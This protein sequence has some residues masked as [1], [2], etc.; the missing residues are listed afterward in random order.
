M[1][2]KWIVALV[3]VGLGCSFVA[4]SS[5]DAAVSAY[6]RHEE[7]P[8]GGLIPA[9]ENTVLD[10]SG[11]GNHMQTFNPSFTSATYTTSVSPLPL[12]SG[13]SNT[14]SLDFGP[15]GDDAGLNDDNYT[16][17]KPIQSQLFSAMT[18]E[19]AFNMDTVAGYQALFGRDG[20]PLGGSPVPPIKFLVRGDDFPDAVPNQLFIEFIDG[21]GDVHFV[22]S[23]Q[24]VTPGT[25]NHVAFTLSSTTAELW[26][27]GEN[28]PYT[29]LDSISGDFAG[30][31]GEVLYSDPTSFS[32]GRGAFN[33]SVAD[34]ADARIDEVRIADQ[35]LTPGGF[36][37]TPVPEPHALALLPLALLASRRRRAH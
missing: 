19:L 13:L 18:I 23:G 7:G 22:N 12:R 24:T 6:W 32:I 3:G 31:A 16:A 4:A 27:A 20:K 36:L 9:G 11:N 37:F 14:Y 17:G 26:L 33:N 29:L 8:N 10:S 21:D 28:T 30:G 15:G 2:S 5:A 1:Q 25:W 35:V 34:W